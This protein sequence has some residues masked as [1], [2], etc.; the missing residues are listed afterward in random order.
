MVKTPARSWPLVLALALAGL[1]AAPERATPATYWFHSVR[2]RDITVCF[3][4]NAVSARLDR[5]REIVTHLKQFGYAA[6]IRFLSLAGH[7]LEAELGRGGNVNNLAC[8]APT[9]QPNG[10]SYYA[11]DIR[12]ALWYTN[13][14]LDPPGMVP[15]VGC[16]QELVGSSWANPPDELELKR[17]CQYN[18]KLGDDDWDPV[19]N[20][21]TGVPWLNHTLHEFGHAL[22]LAHEFLRTDIDP[23]CGVTGTWTDGWITAAWDRDSVMNYVMASCNAWGNYDDTGFSAGDKLALHI[24]YPEDNRVAEIAGTTVIKTGETLRLQ[25][26]WKSQ[27]ANMSFV[28]GG[29]DWRLDGVTRSTTADLVMGGL[30]AGDHPLAF[31]FT[32]FLGRNYSFGGTV[33]VLSSADYDRQMMSVMAGEAAML[34]VGSATVNLPLIVNH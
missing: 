28:A 34:A 2:G 30:A 4:G 16:T 11:G 18:L 33:R 32:D 26:L 20:V 7:T 19:N 21:H 24:M 25:A 14:P 10:N 12:V 23:A 13:V 6:N 5:V 9:T 15:G 1:L 29:Y 3:A 31:S 17:P 27:G 22:G 8:P